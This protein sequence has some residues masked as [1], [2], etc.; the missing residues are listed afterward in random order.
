MEKG[1]HRRSGF[2]VEGLVTSR[3]VQI[4][5]APVVMV[6]SAYD[7]GSGERKSRERIVKDREDGS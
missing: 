7:L 3:G 6:E 4:P 2:F 1:A 5:L